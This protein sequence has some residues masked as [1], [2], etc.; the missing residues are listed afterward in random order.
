MERYF[1]NCFSVK[2]IFLLFVFLMISGCGSK[3]TVVLLPDLDGNTGAINVSNS[4]GSID[5]E[6]ANKA[7]TVSGRQ[8][9][10]SAPTVLKKEEIDSIFS[11]A[12]KA[13]PK[14]PIHFILYFISNSNDLRTDSLDI[15]PA[16]IQAIKERNSINI[17]IVGHTDTMGSDEYNYNLS[18]DRTVAVASLLVNRGA[19]Q[20]HIN[21]TYHGE[22][23][24]LIPTGDNVS[25]PKNRRVEVVVR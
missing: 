2:F 11:Q 25:E 5:I 14:P 18:K 9:A 6:T 19:Q 3:T 8:S 7:T 12:L 13:Q 16:I 23:N 1:T 22:G 20:N 10:P 15:L 21:T 24:P 4:A 17:T